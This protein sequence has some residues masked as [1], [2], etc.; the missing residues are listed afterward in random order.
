MKNISL[1]Y[2]LLAIAGCNSPTKETAVPFKS[3]PP[4][5]EN[6]TVQ[7]PKGFTYT[8]LFSEGDT[9]LNSQGL[10]TPA[11][12]SQDML[13]YMPIKKSSEH[14]YLY[15]NHEEHKPKVIAITGF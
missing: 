13:I 7:L 14:G 10:R 15:V 1:F 3:V 6:K 9:L 12:G 4:D 11:K 2:L 5:F 8:I